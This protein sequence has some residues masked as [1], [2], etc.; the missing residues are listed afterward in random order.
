MESNKPPK[1]YAFA[2]GQTLIPPNMMQK[3]VAYKIK[4]EACIANLSGTG[5]GKTLSAI[6][7]SRVIDSK[8]TIV[9]CPNDIVNEWKERIKQVFPDSTVIIG[10]SAF[11]AQYDENKY[12][13]LVLNYD[14]FNQED[15]PNV[16][17]KLGK[18]QKIDFAILDE[19]QFSKIRYLEDISQRRHNLEGLMTE[20]RKKN[21]KVKVLSLSATPVINNLQEGISFVDLTTSIVHHDLATNATIPNAM[22]L[23]NQLSLISIRDLPEYK[24]NLDTQYDVAEAELPPNMDISQLKN[25]PLSIEQLLTEAKLPKIISRIRG[26]TIIYT[27]Y[28]GAGIIEKISKAVADAGYTYALHTGFDHSGKK[29]FMDKKVQV[30]IAST[31]ITVGVDGLQ[32]VC[33]SQPC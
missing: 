13:Y 26:Q 16:V 2:D 9:V 28:V 20:V 22:A 5:S 27:R 8:M 3:Y 19:T 4:T 21:D 12:Q 14:K 31:P 30:L 25:N 10:K 7:A 6:L 32:K 15:S 1:G 11:N 23:H 24:T 18:Q 33:N 29:R 17:L